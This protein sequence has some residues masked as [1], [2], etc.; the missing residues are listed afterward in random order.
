M[1]SIQTKFIV[2]ILGCVLLS[3]LV[4][5]GAGILGSKRAVD[6][7]STRIMTLLSTERTQLIDAQLSRVEQSVNTLAVYATRQIDDVD[8]IKTND[9]YK[10][11]PELLERFE[12][13]IEEFNQYARPDSKISIGRGIAIYG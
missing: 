11:Y 9:D 7:D 4:V 12:S 1:K 6:K 2:L 10:C 3:C 13:A 5:G 8:A